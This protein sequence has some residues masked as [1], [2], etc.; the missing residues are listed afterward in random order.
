MEFSVQDVRATEKDKV[1]IYQCFRPG[2]IVRAQIV[3]LL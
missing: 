2:D 3:S 1:K